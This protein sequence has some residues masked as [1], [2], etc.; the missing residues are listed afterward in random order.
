[1]SWFRGSTW[2]N[3]KNKRPYL[4]VGVARSANNGGPVGEEM[5]VYKD[6]ASMELY[7][8]NPTEFA[9]K[10]ERRDLCSSTTSATGSSNS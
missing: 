8:R 2:I 5:V 3:K 1:M 6:I 10:F 4:V 7:Y 9:E